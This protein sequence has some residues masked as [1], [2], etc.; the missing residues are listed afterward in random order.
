MLRA[1]SVSDPDDWL[2]LDIALTF[3]IIHP[4][5]GYLFTAY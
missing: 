4:T 5:I 2:F 3:E 1:F